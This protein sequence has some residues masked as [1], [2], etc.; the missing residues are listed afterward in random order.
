MAHPLPFHTRSPFTLVPTF[1]LW[2]DSTLAVYLVARDS[3]MEL[4]NHLV[5]LDGSFVSP[6]SKTRA[7]RFV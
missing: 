6:Y 1:F 3:T 7:P 5:A 2:P 4:P